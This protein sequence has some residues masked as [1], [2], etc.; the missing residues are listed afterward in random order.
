MT[1][2]DRLL[3][4]RLFKNFIYIFFS[5]LFF[6]TVFDMTMM[7]SLPNRSMLLHYGSTYSLQAE[8][9]ISIAF[10]LALIRTLLEANSNF[11]LASLQIAGTPLLKITRMIFVFAALLT[12]LNI[13]NFQYW[14]PKA[15][16][17][18]QKN[19]AKSPRI[20]RV[21]LPDN[22]SLFFNGTLSNQEVLK[23]LFLIKSEEEIW[24]IHSLE[25]SPP[26]LAKGI[27][28]SHRL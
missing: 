16:K 15:A 4:K 25:K 18:L 17:V 21:I 9:L 14:Y 12:C 6:F 19:C 7:K 13:I 28:C 11:E 3:F 2:F 24:H 20:V 22:A 1:I 23:D 8:F 10:A 26:Y 27:D 5:L